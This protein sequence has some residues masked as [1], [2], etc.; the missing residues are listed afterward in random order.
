VPLWQMLMDRL[1]PT[2][3]GLGP[4]DENEPKDQSWPTCRNPSEQ[5]QRATTTQFPN[6]GTIDY[7]VL[8][9]ECVLLLLIYAKSDQ[10]DV[11]IAEIEEAIRKSS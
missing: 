8:S 6:F 5:R 11:S 1:S 10:A 9:P 7:Q 2:P 4:V 3:S